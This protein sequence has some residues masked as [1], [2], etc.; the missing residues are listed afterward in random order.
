M[1][2][3]GFELKKLFKNKGIIQNAKAYSYS[4][5]ITIGPSAICIMLVLGMQYILGY[6]LP[7]F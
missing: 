4:T 5:I 6:Y 2:G 7:W 3:I 1:A